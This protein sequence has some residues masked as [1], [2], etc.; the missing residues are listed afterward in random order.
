MRALHAL[1]RAKVPLPVK[2]MCV[3]LLLTALCAPARRQ[4]SAQ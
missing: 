1:L 4:V 3:K 2:F